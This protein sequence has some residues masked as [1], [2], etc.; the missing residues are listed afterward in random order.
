MKFVAEAVAN[1]AE[2]NEKLFTAKNAVVNTVESKKLAT[3]KES[4][5]K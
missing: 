5:Q 3:Q 2:R 1:E 4:T